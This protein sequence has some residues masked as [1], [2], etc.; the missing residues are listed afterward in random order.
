MKWISVA[1]VPASSDEV[2]KGNY[3]AVWCVSDTGELWCY[4]P[5]N[6]KWFKADSPEAV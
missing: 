5:H 3:Y 2:S 1:A 4:T 6:Q